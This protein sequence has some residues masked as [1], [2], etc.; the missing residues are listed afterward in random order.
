MVIDLH[1]QSPQDLKSDPKDDF[2][3]ALR[4]VIRCIAYPAKYF[5][6][7]IRLSINKK[8]TDENALTR[9]IT[10]R[11]EVDLKVISEIY[12]MRNSVPLDHAVTRD[13]SGDYESMLLALL[14][15]G[16]A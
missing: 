11:A 16:D 15:R 3:A 6:K 13:T 4:A 1:N 7:V 14:G 9:V 12:Q 2:L 8:G 5:E 10:T